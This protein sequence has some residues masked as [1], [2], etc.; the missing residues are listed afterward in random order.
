MLLR[1]K[2]FSWVL[3][4]ARGVMQEINGNMYVSTPEK[5]FTTR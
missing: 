1:G 4:T 2:G 3:K 5:V